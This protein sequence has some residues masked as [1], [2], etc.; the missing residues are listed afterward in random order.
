MKG[1][2]LP[3]NNSL[4]KKPTLN[5]P[6]MAIICSGCSSLGVLFSKTKILRLLSEMGKGIRIFDRVSYEIS[7]I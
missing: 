4:C 1:A 2:S 6:I 5:Y 3:I 7:N